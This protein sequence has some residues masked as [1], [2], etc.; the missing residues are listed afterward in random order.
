MTVIRGR[1][2]WNWYCEVLKNAFT[3]IESTDEAVSENR[4]VPVLV[5][6]GGIQ[7]PQLSQVKSQ[8]LATPSLKATFE[9]SVNFISQ[10]LDEK[11]F[12]TSGSAK[13]GTQASRNISA[14]NS[15]GR[16]RGRGNQRGGPGRGGG[17]SH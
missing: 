17:R 15:S 10:F 4:K 9:E 12:M 14:F 1:L 16:G 6:F 8:V 7:D 11:K 2:P 3:D 13:I 5:L